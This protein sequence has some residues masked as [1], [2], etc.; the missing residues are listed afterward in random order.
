MTLEMA[1]WRMTD[2]GPVPLQYGSL[3]LERR[4]E[5]MIVLDPSLTLAFQ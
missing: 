2:G 4:L 5:D 3:D 1:I